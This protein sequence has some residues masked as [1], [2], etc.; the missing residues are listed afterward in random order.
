MTQVAHSL[1]FLK[2]VPKDESHAEG[3]S[4][5]DQP[6]VLNA[7]DLEIAEPARVR[8]GA[9]YYECRYTSLP[10]CNASAS[11]RAAQCVINPYF[12]SARVPAGTTLSPRLLKR[13]LVD[14]LW[15]NSGCTA[16]G[17]RPRSCVSGTAPFSERIAGFV[18]NSRRGEVG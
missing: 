3:L 17:C 6:P 12:A 11:G 1:E 2:R 18:L 8:S 4:G 16:L 9:N 14:N 5:K 7:G 15:T 10:Q 13:V